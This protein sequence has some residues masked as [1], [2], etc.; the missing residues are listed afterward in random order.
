[1]TAAG[2]CKRRR[3]QPL[4]REAGEQ[5]CELPKF[6]VII[7]N[8][9]GGDF[10]QRAVNSL[11]G[12]TFADFETL[13]V[14]NASSDRSF[15]ALDVSALPS[16]T[17]L[18]QDENLGFAKAN[19]LAAQQARGEWLALLNPDAEAA[20]DWLEQ[21]LAGFSRHPDVGMFASAQFDSSNTDRLDGAGDCYL[22]FGIPWRGGFGRPASE[23][24]TEGES[25]SPCGA[26]A[27]FNARLF[28][29]V[30]G[31][32]EDLF[33]F[34]EDVDIGYRLRL[35]G[36][37]CVFLPGATVLHAGGALSGRISDFS[38]RHGARNRLWTY[39]KNTPVPLMVL[40]LPGHIVLTT[41]ILLRG[42]MTGRFVS[43]FKG[44]AEAL[45]NLG[46]VMQK[47]KQVQASRTESTSRI[48]AAMSWNPITML[49]RKPVVTP[50]R[51]TG[52]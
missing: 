37:R 35:L 4:D 13:I 38:V 28:E 12:Q 42:A 1:M 5:E 47:R 50:I 52:Q 2:H 14:D 51:N 34:C 39:L 21:V 11:A 15:S 9:N 43:T 32:D 18:P 36:E 16:V 10:L 7:V 46:P 25:F 49:K 17:L 8:Y 26:A 6:S 27:I 29:S 24:P 44:I 45:G 40:T 48:A 22:G 20:P 41:L 30:G 19:N 33:C 31:F 3:K 23:L